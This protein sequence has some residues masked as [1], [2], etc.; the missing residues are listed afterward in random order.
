LQNDKG[1]A[2][3]AAASYPQMSRG[4]LAKFHQ[5]LQVLEAFLG[6][7][8]ALGEKVLG[9]IGKLADKGGVPRLVREEDLVAAVAGRGERGLAF[10]LEGRVEGE[11]VPVAGLERR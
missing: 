7:I 5:Y 6:S 1:G 4:L 10:R 2:L 11:Q 8:F 3:E 9:A